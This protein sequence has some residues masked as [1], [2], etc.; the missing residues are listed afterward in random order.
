M[1]EVAREVEGAELFLYPG[2]GHLFADSSSVDHDEQ[3]AA[4][5]MRR[6]LDLLGRVS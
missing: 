6:T 4:L 1:E 3:A 5:L 2:A